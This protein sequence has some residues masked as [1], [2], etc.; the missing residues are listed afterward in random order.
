MKNIKLFEEF[1]TESS[2]WHAK[3][4]ADLKKMAR[5]FK[6]DY[7]DRESGFLEP[8]DVDAN[9]KF[10]TDYLGGDQIVELIGG[11]SWG[12]HPN[13]TA[14]TARYMELVSNIKNAKDQS[15]ESGTDVVLGTLNGAKVLCQYDGWSTPTHLSIMVNIKDVKKF[16]LGVDPFIKW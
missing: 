5:S 4:P 11:D 9:F 10:I 6:K 13:A 3:T 15:M 8:E 14:L 1:I 7:Y 16:D 12:D 2:D